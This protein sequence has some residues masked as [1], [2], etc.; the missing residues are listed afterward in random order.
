VCSYDHKELLRRYKI[1]ADGTLKNGKIFSTIIGDGV[2]VDSRRNETS[3]HK[4]IEEIK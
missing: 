2:K 1:A 3:G 4:T